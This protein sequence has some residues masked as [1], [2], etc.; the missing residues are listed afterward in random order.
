MLEP[1]AVSSALQLLS[2]FEAF[3][4]HHCEV[5]SQCH[6]LRKPFLSAPNICCNRVWK[7]SRPN[8]TKG[9]Q[10]IAICLQTQLPQAAITSQTMCQLLCGQSQA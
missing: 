6:F 8:R 10:T 9:T 5:K 1:L 3:F 7:H 2:P 4:I